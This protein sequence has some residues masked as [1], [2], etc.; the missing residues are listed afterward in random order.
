MAGPFFV[1]E[2]VEQD[3]DVHKQSSS[4]PGVVLMEADPK[5]NVPKRSSN[6]TRVLLGLTALG[7]MVFLGSLG[8]VVWLVSQEDSGEVLE[9]SFLQV[10]LRGPIADAPQ[11]PPLFADPADIP[12][13]GIEIAQALR[14][15]ANDERIDGVYLDVANPVMGYGI[16]R[17][18]HD[19]LGEVRAAGKPCVAYSEVWT[20]GSWYVASACDHVVMPPAG[21]G[22]VT[23][24]DART[25]YYKGTFDKLG[26]ES[27]ML[28]VGDFKSA[29]EP[30]ERTEPSEAASEAMNY[31]L[32]G[33][34][35]TW[36]AD[37]AEGRGLSEAKVQALVD[38]PPLSPSAARERG[39][40][41][42][43]AYPAV[44]EDL[45]TEAGAE[46]WREQVTAAMEEAGQGGGG[47]DEE[48]EFTELDEYVKGL[49]A[50]WRA[51]D[52]HVA[53]IYASGPIT[54]GTGEDSLFSGP[55]LTDVNFEKWVRAAT[56][57]ESVKALVIRV[58]SP[59]GSGLASDMMWHEIRR[60]QASGLPVVVSM[61][62]YAASG[63]YYISAPADWVVAQPTTLTG[64]IGVFGGKLN[65]EGL[66]EKVGLTQHSYKRGE[67]AD[68]FALTK[69]FSEGGVE[70]YQ[71]FLDDFYDLF[72]ERVSE[73]RELERGAV[74][75]VAQGRVWTGEQAMERGLVDQ[76][77]GIDVAL[78]KAA[79]L[80]ELDE[81]YGV[82]TFPKQK[83]FFELLQEDLA[84][85]SSPTVEL[86]FGLASLVDAEALRDVL[87]L[88][89][90][91]ADGAAALLP[92]S[93]VIE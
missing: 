53:V 54:T 7:G 71:G 80:A 26:I 36:L 41:D 70:A 47:D 1:S 34:W 68:L 6:T 30:Y 78:A 13:T 50:D 58:D 4:H 23:G 66:Y 31:L 75:Q 88:E 42:V 62:S 27:E 11:P 52:E 25:T 46:D 89:R 22:L 72:L 8:A 40:V 19:A 43:I 51:A 15:A 63:G 3:L 9:G 37:A 90:V 28:H 10:E 83:T 64:S 91:L 65:L 33:L 48:D 56:E 29:V 45:L 73:G 84:D 81:G 44:F 69:G 21:I 39:L 67:Q 92:G 87:V 16:A 57:D 55:T 32:D 79:E 38:R 12:P 18:L 24:I 59:G 77:G 93:L 14:K 35:G 20:T 76:L 5:P 49:R 61:A 17:E 86:E 2:G 82:A 85:A 74:H 60:V